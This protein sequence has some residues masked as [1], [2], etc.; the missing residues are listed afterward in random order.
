MESTDTARVGSSSASA[1]AV[2]AA[3]TRSPVPSTAHPR[4]RLWRPPPGA[5]LLRQMGPPGAGPELGRD[6]VDHLTV[7]PPTATR[8]GARSGGNGSIRAH[9]ASA[10]GTPG[11]TTD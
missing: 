3:S 2:G 11:P 7:V 5:V 4:N 1:R 8:F 9:R 10:G 6:P